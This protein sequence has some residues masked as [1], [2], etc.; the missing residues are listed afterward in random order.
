[1]KMTD[2]CNHIAVSL[3]AEWRFVDCIYAAWDLKKQEGLNSVPMIY[4][5]AKT[6]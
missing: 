3:S 4:R 6:R 2:G 5:Y 1:M